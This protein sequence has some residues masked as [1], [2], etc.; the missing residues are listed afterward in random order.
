MIEYLLANPGLQIEIQGPVIMLVF[1]PPLSA[2]KIEFNL[3]R[4]AQIRA[5]LPEYL[6]N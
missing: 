5:L 2:G 3:P 6:F 1:E 4:L